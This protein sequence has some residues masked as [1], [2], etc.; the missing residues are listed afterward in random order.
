MPTLL[1][2]T[3]IPSTKRSLAVAI[4]DD[5]A[6]I[7]TGSKSITFDLLFDTPIDAVI[8]D[9]KIK[10]VTPEALATRLR[11]TKKFASCPILL[12]VSKKAKP[13]QALKSGIT[14]FLYRPLKPDQVKSAIVLA[15]SY[16][17]EVKH[18]GER[19]KRLKRMAEHDTLTRLYNRLALT[20]LGRKEIS[21]S[22]RTKSPLSVLMIDLDL[23]KRVNDE[24]GHDEGDK[25]LVEIAT[26]IAKNLRAY[27]IVARYG[28]EEFVVLLP[29]TTQEKALVVAEKLRKAVEKARLKLNMTISIGIAELYD[30]QSL[31]TLLK[32][33]DKAMYRA[34]ESGRNRCCT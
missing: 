2:I 28:G 5:F 9:A 4:G 17:K 15:K 27:D 26:L 12:L 23:F 32:A 30:S 1:L 14:N 11:S 18:L 21:K 25:M 7:S 16:K 22:Q 13:E 19:S 33:A 3:D 31:E 24:F 34:K 6:L 29:N 8:I 10:F 20:E